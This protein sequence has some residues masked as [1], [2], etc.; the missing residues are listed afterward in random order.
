M[1]RVEMPAIISSVSHTEPKM[2]VWPKSGWSISTPPTS[3]VS[4]PVIGTTGRCGSLA[5]NDRIQAVAT[6]NRGLRNSEGWNWLIPTPI[7]RRAPLISTPISGVAISS[8]RNTAAPPS[9]KRRAA[10]A[11][12][13]ET[14]II[15]G[16]DSTTH[17]AWRQK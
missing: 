12:S 13:I 8:T 6:I 10:V 7:Q 11:G 14:P 5:R 16:K 3:A 2:I 4:A 15:T 9:A 17:S 1:I